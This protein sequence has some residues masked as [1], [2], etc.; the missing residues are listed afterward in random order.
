MTVDEQLDRLSSQLSSHSLGPINAI[1][2]EMMSRLGSMFSAVV[3]SLRQAAN[4][5]P[6]MTLLLAAQAG[7]LI[8]RLGHRYARN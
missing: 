7:Y 3:L 6:L 4:D 1:S 2:T 8:S 5:Q